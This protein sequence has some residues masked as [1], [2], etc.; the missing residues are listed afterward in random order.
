MRPTTADKF[1]MRTFK[2][3][4]ISFIFSYQYFFHYLPF[5]LS[6]SLNRANVCLLRADFIA[7]MVRVRAADV[8][9]WT[10]C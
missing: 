6:N 1:W 5:V 10:L 4:H 2:I 9:L 3:F 7:V 8:R